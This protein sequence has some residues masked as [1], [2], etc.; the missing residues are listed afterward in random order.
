MKLIVVTAPENKPED[1]KYIQELFHAGLE[2]LHLR[3]PDQEKNDFENILK[4]LPSSLYKRIVIHSHYKLIEKY[5]LKGIHL[6]EWFIREAGPQEVKELIEI[7]HQRR[8]SVSGSFHSIED[9][10]TLQLKLDY[11]FLGPVFDS[12]SK[13]GYKS[14]INISDAAASLQKRKRF[15]VFAIGGISS[16]NIKSLKT[17]GF[18]GAALLGSIW[19]DS[20]PSNSFKNIKNQITA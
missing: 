12:I 9:F 5:N 17:A 16:D 19:S 7:A 14:K 1:T 10:E 6:T 18:D 20:N 3:K 2:S 13:E 8:L 11:V 4:Q 15:E